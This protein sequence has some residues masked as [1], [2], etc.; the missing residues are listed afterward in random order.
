M[1][2]FEKLMLLFMMITQFTL[3]RMQEKCKV[4]KNKREDQTKSLQVTNSTEMNS[5]EQTFSN[6]QTLEALQ[7]LIMEIQQVKDKYNPNLTVQQAKSHLMVL[8]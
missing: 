2:E 5:L 3:W 7:S 6:L 1:K 8:S 4:L